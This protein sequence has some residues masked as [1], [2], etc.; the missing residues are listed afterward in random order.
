MAIENNNDI[1][2]LSSSQYSENSS[3]IAITSNLGEDGSLASS[4]SLPVSSVS[5]ATTTATLVSDLTSDSALDISDASSTPTSRSNA[6]PIPGASSKEI[7]TPSPVDP[8]TNGVTEMSMGAYEPGNSMEHTDVSQPPSSTPAPSTEAMKQFLILY[9]SSLLVL[10]VSPCMKRFVLDVRFDGDT[11]AIQAK[12]IPPLVASNMLSEADG[13]MFDGTDSS[14]VS[15]FPPQNALEFCNLPS[16]FGGFKGAKLSAIFTSKIDKDVWLEGHLPPPAPMQDIGLTAPSQGT[17]ISSPSSGVT[18]SSSPIPPPPP[19]TS[20]PLLAPGSAGPSSQGNSPQG[21][22]TVSVLAT[23]CESDLPLMPSSDPQ[24]G[25]SLPHDASPPPTL[26]PITNIPPPQP[27]KPQEF[28]GKPPAPPPPAISPHPPPL[29]PPPSSYSIM[30]SAAAVANNAQDTAKLG[31]SSTHSH[32]P[33]AQPTTQ[34]VPSP[35]P[36][37]HM[38]PFNKSATLP[39]DTTP[40][41]MNKAATLPARLTNRSHPNSPTAKNNQPHL[42]RPPVIPIH[43]PQWTLSCLRPNPPVR[44]HLSSPQAFAST[45]MSSSTR[46]GDLSGKSMAGSM[47]GNSKKSMEDSLLDEAEILR[48]IEAYCTTVKARNTVNSTFIDSPQVLIAEEEKI[49]VEERK[50]NQLVVEEKTLV[51]TVYALKDQVADILDQMKELKS[52]LDYERKARK[53]MEMT[54]RKNLMKSGVHDTSSSSMSVSMTSALSNYAPPALPPPLPPPLPSQ[55]PPSA[56]PPSISITNEAND[57]NTH[58]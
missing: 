43:H 5:S 55:P 7:N 28:V 14:T 51:D 52:T 47:K 58:V 50:G 11:S 6:I 27:V 2:T 42:S 56:P 34:D 20:P 3:G 8:L 38:T 22:M 31:L 10:S 29:P 16:S 4:T 12:V 1:H 35:F 30:L 21:V 44:P 17:S 37:A 33:T 48:V 18:P 25:A 39:A 26:V 15:S 46:N 24:P 53:R 32:S 57:A 23:Q 45:S 9:P 40:S 13:A 19:S 41:M 36:H 54:V 49:I